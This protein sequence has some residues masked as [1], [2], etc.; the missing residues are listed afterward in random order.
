[1]STAK[2]SSMDQGAIKQVETFSMDRGAIEKLL[3]LRLKE[4][5]ELDR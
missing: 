4:A 3:R 5:K 2:R 1:M